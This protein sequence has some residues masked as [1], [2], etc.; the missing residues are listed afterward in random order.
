M[1][2]ASTLWAVVDQNLDGSRKGDFSAITRLVSSGILTES[3]AQEHYLIHDMAQR[4][5]WTNHRWAFTL[6][7]R[8]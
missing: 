8:P 5:S 4:E 7:P 1:M 3:V 2:N 6:R